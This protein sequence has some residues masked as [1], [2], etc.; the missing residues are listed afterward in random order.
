M[1]RKKVVTTKE[2][3]RLRVSFSVPISRL[4]L[5]RGMWVP[6][7]LYVTLLL[8]FTQWFSAGWRINLQSFALKY[9]TQDINLILI[10][11]SKS[12]F[13]FYWKV[14]WKCLVLV[15]CL[16]MRIF[17]LVYFVELGWSTGVYFIKKKTI[18][19]VDVK[20]YQKE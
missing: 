20:D 19:R 9:S 8:A 12:S 13:T 18:Y 5:V 15:V 6:H 3:D 10:A 7:R 4:S 11:V 16:Y 17:E 2:I 14:L 1:G